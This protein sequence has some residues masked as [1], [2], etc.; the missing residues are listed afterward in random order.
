MQNTI[1]KRFIS[2]IAKDTQSNPKSGKHPSSPNQWNFAEDLV[3]ELKSIGAQVDFDDKHCY[4]YGSIPSNIS[5]IKEEKPVIAFIAHM[6]TA[7]EMSGHCVNPQI[8][9]YEGGEINRE[10]LHMKPE[11]FPALKELIGE[12]II[13][14]DGTTLLGADDKAGI[15]EIITA[16]EYLL[17]H[18]EIPRGEIRFAFTPDEEIGEGADFFD[19]K[20]LGADFAYTMDGGPLGE[21]EYESFN[22]ASAVVK[23]KG[24]S[25]HPGSAKNAMVNASLLGMEFH[26]LLP[27]GMRPELTEG[28]EGFFHLLEITGT[29][30][31]A[32]LEYIIRD[33]DRKL[34]KEKKELFQATADFLNKKYGPR[35]TA[36]IKDSYYNMGDVL[37]DHPQVINLAKQ[38][39]ENLKIT[40][41]IQPIRGGTDGSKLS[42]MG[43]PTPNIFVGGYH[44]HGKY[45][46]IPLSS[47]EKA[48]QVILEI[49]RLNIDSTNKEEYN[50]TKQ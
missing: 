2:Y 24:E 35:F 5:N 18:P 14:T 37:K 29:A 46:M 26:N 27:I 15:T 17:T 49:N 31:E 32:T 48:V 6:D 11:D 42:F 12:K 4:I 45:E 40:P 38:A 34:F 25:I 13:T 1:Q 36:T 19:V 47:M 20:R 30:E 39:M 43:L 8:F 50:E 3:E 16:I 28:Y 21:L 41:K 9:V 7:S 23:I 33:H 22:A 10:Q 44:Y